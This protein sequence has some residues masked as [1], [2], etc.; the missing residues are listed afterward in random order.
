M[1]NI[2]ITYYYAYRKHKTIES[3]YFKLGSVRFWDGDAEEGT[4]FLPHSL[5]YLFKIFI[6][7]Y[8][9]KK[10]TDAKIHNFFVAF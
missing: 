3:E 9:M 7:I 2:L 8:Y 1:I 6:I 10:I 5:V 4:L